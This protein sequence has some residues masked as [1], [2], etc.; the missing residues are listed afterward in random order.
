MENPDQETT[1]SEENSILST[2]NMDPFSARIQ[3]KTSTKG[4]SLDPGPTSTSQQ[5]SSTAASR[6]RATSSDRD[7]KAQNQKEY[8][9]P[10]N[11]K[12][13]PRNTQ[14]LVESWLETWEV[15]GTKVSPQA[16]ETITTLTSTELPTKNQAGVSQNPQG[17][18]WPSPQ[19]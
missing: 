13:K 15:K 11:T 18:S 7:W 1:K 12:T 6:T 9:D 16:Q 3:G 19:S 14:K 5:F 2:K 17:M 8:Q 4:M 10:A